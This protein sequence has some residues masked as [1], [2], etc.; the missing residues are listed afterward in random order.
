MCLSPHA[1]PRRPRA[2]LEVHRDRFELVK[3]GL[4]RHIRNRLLRPMSQAQFARWLTTKEFMIRND[5]M[6]EG[7]EAAS[8]DDVSAYLPTMLKRVQV[9]VLAHGNLDCAD[10]SGDGGIVNILRSSL[11]RHGCAP[12]PPPERFVE[13]CLR[14]PEGKRA[15]FVELGNNPDEQ[16]SVLELYYQL[17]GQDLPSRSLLSLFE[18]CIDEKCFNTL[19]TKQQLGYSVDSGM[20]L[21]HGMLGFAIRVQSASHDPNVLEERADAFFRDFVATLGDM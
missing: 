16:N 3:D 14:L 18:Q 15:L 2:A 19:R 17:C 6:L 10:V 20:R 8:A 12:I 13:R 5:D 21:T 4:T 11:A 7:I 1:P 9:E